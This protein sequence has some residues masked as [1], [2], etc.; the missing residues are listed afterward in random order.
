MPDVHLG[1][2]NT[3]AVWPGGASKQGPHRVGA[4]AVCPQLE[5][6]GYEL[7]LRPLA[8]YKDAAEI[9]TLVH[10]GLAY[11]Y[12][13]R[14]AQRPD[15]LV[16]PDG[17]HAIWI[18]G[19][20]RPDTAMEALRIYDAYGAYWDRLIAFGAIAM[21]KPLLVEHQFEVSFAMPDGSTEPYTARLDL[22]AEENG[23]VILVD[24][25]TKGKITKNTGNDYAT[26]RQMLTQLALCRVY[27][28]NVQRIV[29]NALSRE[30]PEPH[31]G[32]FDVPLS[33]DAYNR[34]AIDTEHVLRQMRDVRTRHPDPTNRPRTW[35]NCLRKYG[36]CE[37]I[38]LCKD[39][40][41]R[42]VEYTKRK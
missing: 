8:G 38:P 41:H 37:F 7:Y 19:Q 5:G 39:G 33:S 28:Y 31:F 1:H 24:H 27:G 18:C 12:G 42:I 32:R 25:K 4:F 14:L 35:E 16:Y 23:Q 29:I 13:M 20:E 21:W 15:W 26:D 17:R 2:P 3:G 22:L 11:R 36:P 10:V 6:F 30:Y 40:M 9:G 34:L